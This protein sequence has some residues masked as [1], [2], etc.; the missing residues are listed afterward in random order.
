M[1]NSHSWTR[2]IQSLLSSYSVN[3]I[4]P[5]TLP[6]C[7]RISPFPLPVPILAV[8]KAQF[9]CHLL[10]KSLSTFPRSELTLSEQPCVVSRVSPACEPRLSHPTAMEWQALESQ[11]QCREGGREKGT[12]LR[13]T[14]SG[15][16][17]WAVGLFLRSGRE[18]VRD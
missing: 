8:L 13:K 12:V 5:S 4:F 6:S 3:S 17:H 14:V 7:F 9:Q 15:R 18:V 2:L 10:C 11:A 1:G 16:P